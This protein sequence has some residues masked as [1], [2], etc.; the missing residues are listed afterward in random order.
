MPDGMLDEDP[1]PRS[2]VRRGMALL[3]RSVRTHPRPFTIAVLGAGLFAAMTVGSTIVLGRVTDEVVVPGL[4]GD[5]AGGPFGPVAGGSVLLTTAA[6]VIVAL[7]RAAG[8]VARRYFCG[9]TT[10]RMGA[11]WREALA[12]RYLDAPLR[13]HSRRPAGE[14][15]AH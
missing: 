10:F 9:M 2:V 14:L 8:V 1:E 3:W 12:D 15:M 11:T 7:A 4:A 5:R 6:V 13:F